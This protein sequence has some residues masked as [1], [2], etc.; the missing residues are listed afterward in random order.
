MWKLVSQQTNQENQGF[1]YGLQGTINGII[2]FIFVWLLGF[3]V[4][5]IWAKNVPSDDRTPFSVYVYLIG[6]FLIVTSFLVLFLVPEK[7]TEK[8]K[9]KIT[10]SLIKE[11]I[12]SM[13]NSMKN[14]KLWALSLFLM[15]MY[16]FKSVFAFYLLQMMSNIFLSPP[17]LLT[18]LGGIRTYV[19]RVGVSAFVG[20]WADKFRS[21]VLFLLITLGFG[22]ILL[23]F[24]ILLPNMTN[25][26]HS[27]AIVVISAIMYLL[28][29]VLSWIMVTLRYTQ[30]GEVHIDKKTMLHQLVSFL[31]LVLVQM[32]DCII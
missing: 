21:Y 12:K 6:S 29:G 24:F 1:A 11:N 18:V 15:G 26:V 5:N 7:K 30:L 22:I 32:H 19:L 20:R 14:W 4:T 25:N 2:A 3:I 27:M 16:T 23:L 17:I 31:S 9:Q 13:L 8:V 28:A 10:K